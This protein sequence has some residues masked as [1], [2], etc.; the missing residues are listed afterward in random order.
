VG[1]DQPRPVSL[2]EADPP[3]PHR[4]AQSTNNLQI[5]LFTERFQTRFRSIKLGA[6]TTEEIAA[7]LRH[8]WPVDQATSLRIAVGSGGC[9]R[10]ALADLESWMDV[11]GLS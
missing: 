2:Q 3:A 7:M 6:S 5:D 9:V 11:E 8:H 1:I 4:Q 10:A